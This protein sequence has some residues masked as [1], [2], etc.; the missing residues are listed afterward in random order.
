MTMRIIEETAQATPSEKEYI[1]N[2]KDRNQERTK[3]TEG[4]ARAK[5]AQE[6]K[7]AAMK[8]KNLLLKVGQ[9]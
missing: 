4:E 7:M 6:K 1:K 5:R 3:A 2:I 8:E 9:R